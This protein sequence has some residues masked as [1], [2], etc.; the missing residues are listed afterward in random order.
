MYDI[1]FNENLQQ[2]MTEYFLKELAPLG[3][4]KAFGKNEIIDPDDANSVYI[5]L[6]GAFN[7]V[8]YSR[9][10]DEMSFFRLERGTIFGEMDFFDGERTCVITK[11]LKASAVSIVPRD[12]L[13]NE[14]IKEPDIYKHFMHSIIRKYRIVMLESADVKFNDALGKLAHVL[15]RLAHTTNYRSNKNSE[16][17]K[18]NMTFTHEELANRM[19]ANRSTIT[20]GLK[21]FK[22][23][24]LITIKDRQIHITNIEGLKR[25][26]TPYWSD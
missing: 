22:D 13:E 26:I 18:I 11:A 17:K 2:K 20:N 19:A 8:L 3:V 25:Y 6:D 12:V 4:V 15:V 9:D 23:Q 5:V 21:Y 24:N 14:L 1:L 7:Q 16:N 10:G